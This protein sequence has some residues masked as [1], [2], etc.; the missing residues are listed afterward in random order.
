MK[1]ITLDFDDQTFANIR[2]TL[3]VRQIATGLGGLLDAFIA[4][5]VESVDEGKDRIEIKQK[6]DLD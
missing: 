2:R 6:R 3:Q 5:V 1:T 4:K